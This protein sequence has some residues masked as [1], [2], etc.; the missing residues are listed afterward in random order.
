MQSLLDILWQNAA[1]HTSRTAK[2]DRILFMLVVFCVCIY[3]DTLIIFKRKMD[4]PNHFGKS[5]QIGS[6]R[7]NMNEKK[8]IVINWTFVW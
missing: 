3:K 6:P 5:R 8:W 2:A 4:F 1:V 7:T